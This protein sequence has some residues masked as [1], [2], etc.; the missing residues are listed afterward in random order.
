MKTNKLMMKGRLNKED[1]NV[2]IINYL[3]DICNK[4]VMILNITK[5][6]AF[7]Y[8]ETENDVTMCSSQLRAKM[9][10][11]KLKYCVSVVEVI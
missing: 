9:S 4:V 6:I 10:K 3:S 8:K 2:E 1:I 11:T 5:L 7:I